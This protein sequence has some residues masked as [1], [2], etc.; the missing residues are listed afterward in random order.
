MLTFLA[1]QLP[2]NTSGLWLLLSESSLVVSEKW[3]IHLALKLYSHR[4]RHDRCHSTTQTEQC[5]TTHTELSQETMVLFLFWRGDCY[6]SNCSRTSVSKTHFK[7]QISCE[8]EVPRERNE[9]SGTDS[10]DSQIKIKVQDIH[11]KNDIKNMQNR[12]YNIQPVWLAK[13]QYW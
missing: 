1:Q 11:T 5:V 10:S 12:E 2:R 8:L 6:S 9:I 3:G 4:W 7:E 13:S